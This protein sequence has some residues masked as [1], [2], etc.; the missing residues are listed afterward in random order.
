VKILS[1]AVFKEILSSA[2]LGVLLFTFVL[3]LQR[4]GSLRLFEL[5]LRNSTDWRTAVYLFLLVIP[6]TSIFTIPIGV[7]VGTLVG[8]SRMSSDNEV[9]AIRA[10]GVPV[11]RLLWPVMTFGFLAFLLTAA[12]TTWL[13]PWVYRQS[14]RLMNKALAAQVT[15]EIQPRVFEEGFPNTILYVG[16]VI[17]GPTV[18]WRRIFMADLRKGSERNSSARERGDEP[19]II[20]GAEALAVSDVKNNRIQLAMQQAKTYEIGKN[21]NQDYN[22][23]AERSDLGLQAKEPNEYRRSNNFLEMDTVPLWRWIRAHPRAESVDARLEFHQRLALPM[24]CLLLAAVAIPLGV[25]RR[26]AGKSAAFVV[27]VALAFLYYMSMISLQQMARRGGLPAEA[28]IWGPNVLFLTLSVFL[29]ARLERPGDRDVLG[30]LQEK[31]S[32]FFARLRGTKE[33]AAVPARSAAQAFE[34]GFYK[35]VKVPGIPLLSLIMDAYVLRT[36]VFYF[37]LLLF[38]FVMMTEVFTFFELLGDII[39]NNIATSKVATYLLFLLPKLI[40]DTAPVSVLVAVLVTF[41]VMT[42]SN[43]VTAFKASG[44]SLHRL[45]LP[46]VLV[47]LLF[48]GA[49]FAFDYYYVPEANRKQDALRSEIKG[50]AVQT[51]VNPD[52]K[53]IFGEGCRIFYYKFLDPVEKVMVNPRVY[54]LDC[55]TFS[56]K[57]MIAAERARWE[58]TLKRWVFQSG[59][60]RNYQGI[61]STFTGF[62]DST[63]TFPELTERPDYFLQELIQDKQMN[64]H[65]LSGYIQ[66]LQQSGLDTTRLQV[67]F[68]KKFAVPLFAFIMALLSVPFA[69]LTG[70]RG[71]MAGV[72]VSFTVAI[73]YWAISGFFEQIG[74]VGQLPAPMAAWS[75]DA[76]FTLIGAW[77][78]ARLRT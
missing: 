75:P 51:Y 34:S 59:Y 3:F 37:L 31:V 35:V 27:T 14:T 53:F 50:K 52:R 5:V 56:M 18:K 12:A 38:S 69:F 26:K 42:K 74:N 36:F 41:G 44:V 29:M 68:H 66:T 64:F 60:Q 62:E 24:A 43:E 2:L 13:T 22:T 32:Q 58:P 19:R 71:A 8:L 17:A 21:P 6:P 28:A 77:L 73:A 10:T 78:L 72:G 39:R 30:V 7:L 23:S 65:Q 47:S 48:S 67:Q 76:L 9:T 25:S 15:A 33:A 4:L 20:L 70:S 63:A 16:D 1:R 57:R 54:E 45:S 46:V 61:R 55:E 49:L 11:R 40:Y